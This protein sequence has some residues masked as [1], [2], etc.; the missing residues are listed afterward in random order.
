MN[1]T[2]LC[3]LNRAC[4]LDREAC[5]IWKEAEQ[6]GIPFTSAQQELVRKTAEQKQWRGKAMKLKGGA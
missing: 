3:Y 6:S 4:S 2:C 1:E 5:V